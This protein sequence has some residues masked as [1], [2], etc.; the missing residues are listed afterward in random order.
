MK[1]YISIINAIRSGAF[2]EYDARS[3]DDQSLLLELRDLEN[4][5]R[6]CGSYEEADHLFDK[7]ELIQEVLAT[8]LFKYDVGLER[9]L[10]DTVKKYDRCDDVAERKRIFDS[11]R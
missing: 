11:L 3:V 10:V 6:L 9:P 5:I 8:I 2:N 4:Q 1:L 7:L